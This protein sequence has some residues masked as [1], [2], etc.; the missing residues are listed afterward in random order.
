M[1]TNPSLPKASASK[2]KRSAINITPIVVG[3]P[4]NLKFR[5]ANVADRV[6]NIEMSVTKSIEFI[7][8]E[9]M[10]MR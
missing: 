4:T 8:N 7:S 6:N 1:S 5:Y 2:E 3:R 9:F 10:K